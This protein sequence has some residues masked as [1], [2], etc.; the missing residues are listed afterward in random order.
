MIQLNSGKTHYKDNEDDTNN[1]VGLRVNNK[2]KKHIK[3]IRDISDRGAY[4]ILRSKRMNSKIIQVYAP[5]YKY[6]D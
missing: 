3:T 1:G 4:I 2:I 5:T 6:D